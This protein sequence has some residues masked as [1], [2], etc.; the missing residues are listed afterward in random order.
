MSITT[1]CPY[2]EDGRARRTDTWFVYQAFAEMPSNHVLVKVG[3]STKPFERL[4]AIYC[5]SPFLIELAC[6]APA[7]GKKRALGIES[8]TLSE[9]RG[10]ATRGEWLMLPTTADVKRSFAERSS[11]IFKAVTGSPPPWRRV[12][13]DQIR[14]QIA[15]SIKKFA[16]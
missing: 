12:T 13:G 10:Y 1:F 5:N 11:T 2:D 3:I 15:F 9:F 7:G 14:A 8:R 16:A 6:F 4:M